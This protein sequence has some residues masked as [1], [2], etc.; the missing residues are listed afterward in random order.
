MTS[1]AFQQH[2]TLI[3]MR[4]QIT[5]ALWEQQSACTR[6][7]PTMSPGFIMKVVIC[8][9][10]FPGMKLCVINYLTIMDQMGMKNIYNEKLSV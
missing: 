2:D 6:D 8:M 4:G 5:E 7:R 1:I 10:Q 3:W 9:D